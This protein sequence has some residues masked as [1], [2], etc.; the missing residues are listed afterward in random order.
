[1]VQLLLKVKGSFK[2]KLIII[3]QKK[4]K[5]S[6]VKIGVCAYS[7]YRFSSSS[8]VTKSTETDATLSLT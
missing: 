3:C 4:K 1:M 2:S 6:N 7:K 8:F 5:K